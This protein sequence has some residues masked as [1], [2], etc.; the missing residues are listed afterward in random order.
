MAL[1]EARTSMDVAGA[2][3]KKRGVGSLLLGVVV[4][5]LMLVAL[6]AASA[7][8]SPW[9]WLG[10]YALFILGFPLYVRLFVGEKW[11][12][13]LY[14]LHAMAS[15]ALVVG[16]LVQAYLAAVLP[17]AADNTVMLGSFIAALLAFLA[18][19]LVLIL[20]V[21]IAATAI[22][23]LHEWEGTT[24]KD[25]FDYLFS[26]LLGINQP[27][28]VVENG[29]VAE[30]KKKGIFYKMG[31]PGIVVVRPGSAVVLHRTGEITKIGG[32]GLHRA[33]RYEKIRCAVQLGPLWKT[34]K[35]EGALT[36]DG[37]PLDIRLGIG[38]GL[39]SMAD[40]DRRAGQPANRRAIHGDYPIYEDTLRK[41]VL[42]VTPVGWE[43]T[44]SA[45]CESQLR[46]II[47]S[48][49]LDELFGL[50]NI[51]GPDAGEFSENERVIKR[52]EQRVMHNWAV[53]AAENYGIKIRTVDIQAIEVPEPVQ[54]RMLEAWSTEWRE[55]TERALRTAE[56]EAWTKL[57]RIRNE[58]RKSAFAQVFEAIQRGLDI[59]E[60]KDPLFHQYVDTIS[61][62]AVAMS[63]DSASAYRYM[64]AIEKLMENPEAQVVLAA[65][66][67]RLSFDAR[68]DEED[69]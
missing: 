37:V 41:A 15:A 19:P 20:L 31:G 48:Y 58:A 10:G 43:E 68:G 54:E 9:S 55:R 32:P 14:I 38:Y 66:Q 24:G 8:E 61:K 12:S 5:L 7:V 34:R 56:A 46:D 60:S 11:R 2:D 49:T 6:A 4:W 28:V 44:A 1:G 30:S 18:V 42:N 53:I 39:E 27:W 57:E 52:I 16:G 69:K 59:F 62:L 50:T 51:E 63:R 36:R 17:P 35:V 29:K 13:L 65:P 23:G 22:L 33:R 47:G 25:A 3:R 45:G 21:R 40:T 64:E 26:S 67:T